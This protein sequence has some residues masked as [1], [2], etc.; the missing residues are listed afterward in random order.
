MTTRHHMARGFTLIEMMVSLATGLLVVL[1]AGALL[2][3]AHAVYLDLDDAA[4]VQETGRLSLSHLRTVLSQA[5][6]LPWERAL[7]STSPVLRT[8][9]LRGL[10]DRRNA[11][12]LDPQKNNFDAGT[13]RGINQSDILMIGFFGSPDV[14]HV[15]SCGSGAITSKR[16]DGNAGSDGRRSWVIYFIRQTG[17]NEPELHCRYHNAKGGIGKDAVA[18]GIESM[19][20]LYGVDSD[21]VN[22]AD[23]WYSASQM[24]PAL[25]RRVRLV[26]IALLVRGRHFNDRGGA[27]H[28]FDLLGPGP[29]TVSIATDK[30]PPRLRAVFETTVMLRNAVPMPGPGEP[31]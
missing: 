25:W 16:G 3:Q 28:S 29:Q 14:G 20:V 21:T 30:H 11:A 5:N 9:G 18:S 31:R 15:A 22:G 19:Q 6:H 12:A 2:H 8:G 4:L 1:S 26:R 13:E 24:T 23:R 17:N 10:D 27:A 7:Q